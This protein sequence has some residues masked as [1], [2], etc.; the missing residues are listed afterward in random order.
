ML[1][2]WRPVK[3]KKK[4]KKNRYDLHM[5]KIKNKRFIFFNFKAQKIPK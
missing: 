3:N 4:N 2:I 5:N 1:Y